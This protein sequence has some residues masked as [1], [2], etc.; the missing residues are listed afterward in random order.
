MS[1]QFVA[2][3]CLALIATFA[4]GATDLCKTSRPNRFSSLVTKD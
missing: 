2:S 3:V 1:V 4:V